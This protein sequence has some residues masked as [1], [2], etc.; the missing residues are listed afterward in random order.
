M[1]RLLPGFPENVVAVAA[2]GHVTRE[3]YETVLIPHVEAVAK[4]H[5]KIRCYYELGAEFAG[6]APGAMWEDFRIGVEYWTNWER[7]AVVTD[8]SWIARSVA[9]FRF[10]MP[11]RIRVF[12]LS[13]NQA[14]RTWV[15]A[16]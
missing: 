11:G 2:A 13:E 8:I 14:A 5:P 4:N 15:E 6:M 3:D 12:P 16:P 10:L 1:I 7:V 9:A